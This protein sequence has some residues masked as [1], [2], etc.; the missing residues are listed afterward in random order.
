MEFRNG[1]K[2]TLDHVKMTGYITGC[3]LS[4]KLK[5]SRIT[6]PDKEKTNAILYF[7]TSDKKS[8]N[9]LTLKNSTVNGNISAYMTQIRVENSTISA[10]KPFSLSGGS[11]LFL[12]GKANARGG[13]DPHT[14]S[15][16]AVVFDLYDGADLIIKGGEFNSKHRIIWS[17][18]DKDSDV[19]SITIN[20]GKFTSDA[21]CIWQTSY[22]R[23]VK[24][25]ITGGEFTTGNADSNDNN[26]IYND[27][28]TV[29]ITG[30]SFT[31]DGGTAMINNDGS[32]SLFSAY[33]TAK[34]YLGDAISSI[35]GTL[36]IGPKCLI[37]SNSGYAV[38]VN[39]DTNCNVDESCLS[40]NSPTL[41]AFG[42]PN[43]YNR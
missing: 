1:G 16:Q 19:N 24:L 22:Y 4:I 8:K 42:Y 33:V 17:Q 18:S 31:A 26:V 39:A 2:V 32:M 36:I 10:Q 35:G 6:A 15:Q 14:M 5:K 29:Y 21:A 23:T 25:T 7:V 20:D 40:T 38:R 30:G 11:L 13:K 9:A 43:H 12:S 41:Y 28:G 3:D 37:K 27:R 34:S